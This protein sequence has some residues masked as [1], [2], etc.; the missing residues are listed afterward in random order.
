[1]SEGRPSCTACNGRGV[2]G[3]AQTCV[4]CGDV[5]EQCR[6]WLLLKCEASVSG[7]GGHN[8]A[9]K[10]ACVVVGGFG[11]KGGVAEALLGEWNGRCSPPW[12]E[13]ELAHK[14]RSAER[15]TA[16]DAPGYLIW[17][18]GGGD[19]KAGDVKSGTW[20]NVRERER[21]E[22]RRSAVYEPGA[23]KAVVAAGGV[24]EVSREYLA[25]RSFVDP[26]KVKA[27]DFLE[28]LYATG[29][30]V[31]VFT[32]FRSQGDFCY[33]VGNGWWEMGRT[34]EQKNAK[35]DGEPGLMWKE[36]VWFLAQPVRGN[37]M[38]E[39]VTGKGGM[40]KHW[41]RR[42]GAN[43]S[44]WR[45]MVV[46]SDE[47][48]IEAEWL[49]FLALLPLPIVA[50]YT[51]G[52]RSVHALVRVDAAS[53]ADWDAFR[54]A[55]KPLLVKCGADKGVFSA[56][57]LTRLPGY[58]REGGFDKHKVY[59]RYAQPRLQTLLYFNP[60]NYGEST[61]PICQQRRRRALQPT[62]LD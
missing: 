55:V 2:I 33:E 24:G 29:E 32:S 40:E 18:R 22:E 48:G 13:R 15:L 20:A 54:D 16:K 14:L 8:A 5:V 38:A 35:L 58:F 12:S 50:L 30:R 53:K 3:S 11:L 23:L 41:T 31:L 21:H 59:Q 44:A 43:V 1:M 28:G 17:R 7:A 19:W 45:Y 61:V 36:G 27:E 34:A 42:S 25:E 56:V 6:D 60:R 47:D 10:A 49:Q 62:Q 52:G 4:R 37:W 9:L 39:K 26:A 51:S 46:E 57:R